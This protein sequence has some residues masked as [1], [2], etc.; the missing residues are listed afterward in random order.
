[1][2]K[3]KGPVRNFIADW[4]VNI[5]ILLFGITTVAQPFVV[6]TG[7]MENTIMIGDYVIADKLAYA[8]AGPI[9]RHVLPYREVAR[10]DVVVFRYPLNPNEHYVKRVIGMPG[11]RLRIED[12]QV[13]INGAALE[14]PYKIHT[15]PIPLPYRDFFP[16]EPLGY[17]DTRAEEMLRLHVVDG[18]LVIPQGMYFVMGDNRDNSSDSRFWGFVPRENIVG[19]PSFVLWSFDAPTERLGRISVEHFADVAL[20]FFTKTRWDR[21]FQLVR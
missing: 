5:L 20:H 12:R 15:G 11:E 3:A 1:M 9:S 18:E 6:P 10:G 13:Y 2:A 4:A 16:D 8:P 21:T 17:V 7:S 14:E 19:K